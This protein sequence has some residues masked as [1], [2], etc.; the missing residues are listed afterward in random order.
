MSPRLCAARAK[1][2]RRQDHC[3]QIEFFLVSHPRSPFA[4][5]FHLELAAGLHPVPNDTVIV[6]A[7][8]VPELL[9]RRTKI[10]HS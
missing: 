2:R 9:D 5:V 10:G 6:G 3:Q 4:L 1:Q 7:C 8:T